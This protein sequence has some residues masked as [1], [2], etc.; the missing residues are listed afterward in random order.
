MYSKTISYGKRSLDNGYLD[1]KFSNKYEKIL[2]I[3][4]KILW[5]C[6]TTYRWM[7]IQI[8]YNFIIV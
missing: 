1:N 6:Y 7:V 8:S 4:K 5:I 2:K 3:E